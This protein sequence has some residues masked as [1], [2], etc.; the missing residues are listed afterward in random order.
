MI[1]KG[2]PDRRYR[3]VTLRTE[4]IGELLEGLRRFQCYSLPACDELPEGF[5]V[6]DVYH[7]P[8]RQALVAVVYHESFDVVP[9]G[10]IPPEMHLLHEVE[11][12]RRPLYRD[13]TLVSCG[14]NPFGSH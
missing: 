14:P 9:V 4:L 7:A 3:L 12:A 2:K 8:E 13:H 10:Q 11:L 5:E 6:I 1:R